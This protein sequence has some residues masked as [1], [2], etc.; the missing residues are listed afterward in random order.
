MGL[1]ETLLKTLSQTKENGPAFKLKLGAELLK[2]EQ[3]QSNPLNPDPEIYLLKRRIERLEQVSPPDHNPDAEY[4]SSVAGISFAHEDHDSRQ[5]AIANIRPGDV[6]EIRLEDKN[7]FDRS[8][9]GIYTRQGTKIG[10]V[11]SGVRGLAK[12]I[13]GWFDHG[14]IVKIV[15]KE[16]T[17]G[18]DERPK[19]G[20]NI[21]I[22]VW[23]GNE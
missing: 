22:Q 15:A 12:E 8:A 14:C 10:Y 2:E 5:M 21:L 19:R 11:H 9:I 3:E 17:G 18:T 23:K 13:R 20:V 4:S 16:I 1:F 6:L 7:A